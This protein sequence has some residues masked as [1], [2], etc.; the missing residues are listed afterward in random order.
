MN[1][2]L[3]RSARVG[4]P[5][6]AAMALAACGV[7]PPSA[8]SASPAAPQAAD[9]PVTGTKPV[10]AAGM[11]M[12]EAN[13]PA[14]KC[15]IETIGGQAMDG[16]YPE[17][18]KNATVG[19]AGWYFSP[20]AAVTADAPAADAQDAS[21]ATATPADEAASTATAAPSP[22]DTGTAA[23]SAPAAGA[24]GLQLVI[25]MEGG[26]KLWSVPITATGERADVAQFL[27]L[28]AA[29]ASGFSLDLNLTELPAASYSVYVVNTAGATD[30]VCGLGRGFVI[31]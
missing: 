10:A 20:T 3:V 26:Q 17:V 24:D 31:K 2:S 16:V 28:P 7:D 23:A 19:I 6:M 1:R 15:N 25:A 14:V 18:N 29:S 9:A 8:S 4:L 5:I 22:A 11:T 21:A 30:S 12:A 13:A 27:S